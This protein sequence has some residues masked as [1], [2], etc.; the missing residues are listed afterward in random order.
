MSRHFDAEELEQRICR[1]LADPACRETPLYETLQAL[2]N[3]QCKQVARLEQ[4]CRLSDTYHTIAR[5]REL[6]SAMRFERQLQQLAKI[7]RIS[8]HYQQ[9]MRD[10]TV[11]L[12]VVASHDALTGLRN[13]REAEQVLAREWLRSRRHPFPLTLVM[14]DVD[15]FKRINDR[16][17]HAYGDM[18]LQQVARAALSTLRNTDLIVRWGGEEFLVVAPDTDATGGIVLAQKIRRAVVCHSIPA[19]ELVTVSLGVAQLL[20]DETIDGLLCRSD[21]AMYRAKEEGRDRALIAPIRDG[22]I[23]VD[24]RAAPS[25][26][27]APAS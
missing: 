19:R 23:Y 6:S 26:F 8:D 12:K 4:I 21:Q 3:Y 15:Q 1:Q 7:I 9:M 2:W 18:V 5:E 10:L 20:V 24:S 11:R 14:F 17:G 22:E 13:R 27:P 16:F 25:S